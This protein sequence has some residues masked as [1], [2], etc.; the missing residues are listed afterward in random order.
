MIDAKSFLRF[1]AVGAI[2][3]AVDAGVLQ[4]LIFV[5]WGAVAARAVAIPVAV[6][7]TWLLNRTFTFP[8]AQGGPA[9]ASLIRYGAVS[10]FGAAVNFAVYATLVLASWR[11]IAALAAA[12]I[13]AMFVN[14]L[15]SRHFAFRA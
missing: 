11:P 9:F 15:G 14:Y 5:G 13:V 2:G 7:A 4:S 6:F 10:A 8:Q 12:S 3:F 1:G